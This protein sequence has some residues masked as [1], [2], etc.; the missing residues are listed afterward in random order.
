MYLDITK[1]IGIKTAK[2]DE[3]LQFSK[4]SGTLIFMDSNSISTV[5]HDTKQ[6]QEAKHWKN[7]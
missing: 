7:V 5:W 6:I 1:E 2:V 4:G 3:I